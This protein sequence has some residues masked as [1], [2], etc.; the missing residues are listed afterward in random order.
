[1]CAIHNVFPLL[2]TRVSQWQER[3]RSP[4]ANENMDH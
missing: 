1:M 4:F 3:P 2:Q